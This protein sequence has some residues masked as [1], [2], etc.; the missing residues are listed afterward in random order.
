MSVARQVDH[1]RVQRFSPVGRSGAVKRIQG[2]FLLVH[3]GASQFV[4][5]IPTDA[6]Y[7]IDRNRATGGGMTAG[8]DFGLPWSVN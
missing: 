8:I 1:Q 6:R 3:A 7:V 2:G 5:R 4:R